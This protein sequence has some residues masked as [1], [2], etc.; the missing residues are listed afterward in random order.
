MPGVFPKPTEPSQS[1]SHVPILGILVAIA[2]VGVL[3]FLFVT[4]R[5]RQITGCMKNEKTPRGEDNEAEMEKCAESLT[6]SDMCV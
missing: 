2:V 6:H 4:N 1:R 3:C 5:G